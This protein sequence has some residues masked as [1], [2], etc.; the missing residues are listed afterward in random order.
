[1]YPTNSNCLGIED[2]YIFGIFHEEKYL[3]YEER[4]TL[5]PMLE[6]IFHIFYY[7]HRNSRKLDNLCYSVAKNRI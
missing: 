4:M 5:F 3:N 7:M 2:T 1:M 6:I